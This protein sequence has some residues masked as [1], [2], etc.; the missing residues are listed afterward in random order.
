[1]AILKSVAFK[2]GFEPWKLYM[3]EA[4]LAAPLSKSPFPS[5]TDL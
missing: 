2:G 5:Y 4:K 1:M 3:V